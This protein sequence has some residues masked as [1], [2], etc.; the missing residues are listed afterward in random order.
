MKIQYYE[1]KN[2]QWYWRLL[3]D[4]GQVIATGGEGYDSK[5]NVLRAVDNINALFASPM[6]VEE[7]PNS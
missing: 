5:G 2:E 3:A 4:N 6:G 7:K 1:A